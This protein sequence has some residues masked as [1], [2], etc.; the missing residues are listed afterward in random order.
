MRRPQLHFVSVMLIV[1][2][3]MLTDCATDNAKTNIS[4][5]DIGIPVSQI[6]TQIYLTAPLGWN[7]F[8]LKDDITL[9]V[10]VVSENEI[11]F[12]SNYGVRFF[13]N[14]DGQWL[15]LENMMRYPS[16]NLVLSPAKGDYFKHG[17]I[18]A[19]PGFS[20]MD[21]AITVRMY[22]IGNIVKN[23]NI[24]EERTATFIDINLKP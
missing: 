8:K 15:E 18:I 20:T 3:L 7:S 14:S 16:F 12:A 10:E 1:S 5:P 11:A 4:A 23:G 21:K 6:N 24:T 13:T 17:A 9:D 2:C 22:V 19:S